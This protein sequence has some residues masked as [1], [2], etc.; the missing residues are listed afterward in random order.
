MI[1]LNELKRI[2]LE[3][4]EKRQK[5]G[6]KID[7]DTRKMIKHCATEVVESAEAYNSMVD[8]V[9]NKEIFADEVATS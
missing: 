4:A 9:A 5:N 8:G 6:A 7:T 2:A 3:N 1:D